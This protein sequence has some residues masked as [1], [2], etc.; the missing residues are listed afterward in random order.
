MF[1]NET[2]IIVMLLDYDCA[3]C[4]RQL[5]SG[6]YVVACVAVS[7]KRQLANPADAATHFKEQTLFQV[8]DTK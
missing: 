1:R 7:A 5:H 2:I 3:Q 4:R 6:D 8:Q